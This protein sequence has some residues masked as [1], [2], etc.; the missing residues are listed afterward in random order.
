MTDIRREIYKRF[1][2]AGIVI[3]FPQRDVHIDADKPIRIA[4]DPPPAT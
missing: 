2:E 4:I 1:S 3:A